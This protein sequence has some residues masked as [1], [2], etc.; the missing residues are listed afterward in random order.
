MKKFLIIVIILALAGL[1]YWKFKPEPSVPATT[2]PTTTPVANVP[3]N[4]KY[5]DGTYTATGN[6]TS[7]AGAE[8]VVV[9]LVLKD[10][11]VVSATF[12]G[13]GTN[14]TTKMMQG[15]FAAG[16]TTYVVG[17]PLDSIALTVVNGSSLAPKGFMDALVKIKTEAKA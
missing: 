10:D 1:A 2:I 4:K 12:L 6:Y 13:K 14:P 11:E 5:K 3:D 8:Q 15:K 7:P 17:K 9:T 16:F